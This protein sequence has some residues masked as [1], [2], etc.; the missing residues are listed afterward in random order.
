MDIFPGNLLHV[1]NRGNNKQQIFFNE[2][3]YQFFTDKAKKQIAAVA[4]VLAWC[5]MPNHFHFLLHAN[6]HSCKPKKIGSLVSSE[7]Q[8]WFQ[9]VAKFLCQFNK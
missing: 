4:D 1:Y 9:S 6:E 3:N 7:L 5:L 2:D 8:K